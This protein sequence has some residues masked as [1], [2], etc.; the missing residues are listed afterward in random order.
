[1]S[2]D[3]NA[4]FLVGRLTK[5]PELR[6]TQSGTAV[7]SFSIANNRT[8]ITSGE[9][10]EIVSYFNCVA[11][12]K[13]G[14]VITE[15]CKKGHRVGITGRLQQRSW[16]DQ[17]GKRHNIVE[18]IIENIQF[19]NSIQNINQTQNKTD[20]SKGENPFAEDMPF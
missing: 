2:N 11:W 5:N 7:C 9:K 17:E 12:S 16:N 13:L 8:Y 20:S 10:K 14:E 1:M 15:Y 6:Y 19:L 18:I 4:L 3:I